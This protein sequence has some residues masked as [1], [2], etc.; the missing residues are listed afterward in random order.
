MYRIWIEEV[1]GFNLR[2]DRLT[3][4]PALPDDWPGF[5]ITYRYRSAIYH[6]TVQKDP[7]LAQPAPEFLQLVDDGATHRVVVRIPLKAASQML[8]T[9]GVASPRKGVH[10]MNWD[11]IEGKWKQLKGSAKQ[12]WG[13]LT[14]DDLDYISGSKDKLVGRLQERYGIK[15]EDA[16]NRA[17]EWIDTV[18]EEETS[19]RR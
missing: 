16:Q 12:Q 10:A 19:S 13:K 14:D 17:N 8:F 4:R 1:L 6:I 2:G 5:E 11:Q 7:S 18:P 9:D 3:L 15:K